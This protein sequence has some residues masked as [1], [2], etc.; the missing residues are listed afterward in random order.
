VV[1]LPGLTA[2]ISGHPA[3]WGAVITA[4]ETRG[5]VPPE[6]MPTLKRVEAFA[7]D[8][9]SRFFE[10][11]LRRLSRKSNIGLRGNNCL[12]NIVAIAPLASLRSRKVRRL[13][14]ESAVF[15]VKRSNAVSPARQSRIS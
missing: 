5:A 13:Q 14:I 3:V 4:V 11:S 12:A 8:C 7:D 2:T 10:P 15:W 1:P 6:Q 9:P